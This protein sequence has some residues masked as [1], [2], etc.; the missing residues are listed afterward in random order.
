MARPRPHSLGQNAPPP[1]SPSP[2][3]PSLLPCLPSPD[4]L[5][6]PTVDG[7]AAAFAWRSAAMNLSVPYHFRMNNCSLLYPS[8]PSAGLLW[9]LSPRFELHF[10]G[11]HILLQVRI[12][13]SLSYS[14]Y[15]LQAP[16][17][18]PSVADA[19]PHTCYES[20]RQY[21]PFAH[22]RLLVI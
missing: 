11:R 5:E 2:L 20:R 1:P 18:S 16:Q 21:P 12:I 13:Q 8:R 22:Y 7:A 15:P 17:T 6:M 19:P 4:R 9:I 3:P 10:K 14:P